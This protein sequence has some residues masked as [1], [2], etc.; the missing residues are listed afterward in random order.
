MNP[1]VGMEMG[2]FLRAIARRGH[3][4]QLEFV[5]F[6]NDDFL[7]IVGKVQD[8]RPTVRPPSDFDGKG[9]EVV[10]LP[11][12]P[13]EDCRR[14]ADLHDILSASNVMGTTTR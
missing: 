2:G 6:A 4:R 1:A 10:V 14:H 5:L 11:F 3:E 13:H 12:G 8:F 7:V 9:D